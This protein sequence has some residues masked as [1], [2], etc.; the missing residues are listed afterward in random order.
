MFKK[1]EFEVLKG[2]L[3]AG[4]ATMA[5]SSGAVGL[6][7]NSGFENNSVVVPNGGYVTVGAGSSAITG[8]TVGGVSVDLIQGNYN[9]ISNISVDLAGT[10]GPGS[11]SQSF[12]ATA[13]YTYTLD[14]DI[15]NNGG[16]ANSLVVTLGEKTLT[17]SPSNPSYH[18]S[19]S[20]MA[21]LTKSYLVT[22]ASTDSNNSGAVIDNA[23]L[24]AVPEV[25]TMAMSL[26]G[27]GVLCFVARRRRG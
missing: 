12:N 26:A 17:Y 4:L 14:W 7:T 13:G 25:G 3:A 11:V 2:L 16:S 5:A 22:F 21:P 18:A 1:R 8:W 6:L 27:L 9:A 19:F 23:V 10:P 20:W 15:A 24:T